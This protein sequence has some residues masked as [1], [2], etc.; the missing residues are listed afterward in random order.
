M[1]TASVPWLLLD[2][3]LD[4][5]FLNLHNWFPVPCPNPCTSSRFN[6]LCYLFAFHSF[7]RFRGHNQLLLRHRDFFNHL[8][9]FLRLCDNKF[10]WRI[11]KH[12]NGRLTQSAAHLD[13]SVFLLNHDLNQN[14]LR[15][16]PVALNLSIF[17]HFHAIR[18]MTRPLTNILLDWSRSEESSD[19]AQHAYKWWRV[20]SHSKLDIVGFVKMAVFWSQCEEVFRC[21]V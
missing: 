5:F 18:M 20:F 14:R 4:L 6:W 13:T 17:C 12:Y 8:N 9:Y 10:H 15:A 1:R 16:L 21:H 3:S 2:I 19:V 7:C 11:L